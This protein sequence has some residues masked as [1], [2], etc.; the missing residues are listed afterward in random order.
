MKLLFEFPLPLSLLVW[1][2]RYVRNR[3]LSPFRLRRLK[4]RNYRYFSGSRLIGFAEK[5]HLSNEIS[6]VCFI[7]IH[8]DVRFDSIVPI[9]LRSVY[10]PATIRYLQTIYWIKFRIICLSYEAKKCYFCNSVIYEYCAQYYLSRVFVTDT[11]RVEENV[12]C[13]DSW[14]FMHLAGDSGTLIK[15]SRKN[16]NLYKHLQ[17]IER[18]TKRK[19]EREREREREY[20]CRSVKHCTRA[21]TISPS[22]IT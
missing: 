8:P 1:R 12:H 10:F 5:V 11:V 6:A 7:S 2:F 18:L 3:Q 15:K 17:F 9:L 4:Y 20:T 19:R 22:E 14:L 13:Q 21:C 16:K